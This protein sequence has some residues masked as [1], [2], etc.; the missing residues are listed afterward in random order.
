MK[1]PLH[2][3]T[4]QLIL[5]SLAIIKFNLVKRNKPK[6][7]LSNVVISEFNT[8]PLYSPTTNKLSYFN[9][10]DFWLRNTI[11]R[12]KPKNKKYYTHISMFD[13][14][15][16]IS[17][18][19]N[20]IHG[21]ITL[22]IDDFISVVSNL[23][24]YE[25]LSSDNEYKYNK[26]MLCELHKFLFIMIQLSTIRMHNGTEWNVHITTFVTYEKRLVI[27]M[28]GIQYITNQWELINDRDDFSIIF[29]CDLVESLPNS[30]QSVIN[31][32]QINTYGVDVPTDKID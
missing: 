15:L 7:I 9:G 10:D 23:I 14:L 19:C 28:F 5:D 8:S 22:N 4:I 16:K 6:D 18:M 21:N 1:S 2:E 20:N 12:I 24:L 11:N 17:D 26:S 29:G 30:L 13:N 25:R 32:L 31:G 27:G 3:N